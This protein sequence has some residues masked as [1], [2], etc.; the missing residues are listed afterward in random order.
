MEMKR[1][2][3][4]IVGCGPG[5]R[6]CVTAEALQAVRGA[7]VLIGAPRLLEL[8]P[9]ASGER[10]A[11][12][13]AIAEVAAAIAANRHRAVAV[14][15]TGDPG[16]AS[17]ARG[18]LRHFG[19]DACRVIAG[20][21]SVQVA[22]ARLGED[23]T[24]ARILSAHSGLPEVDFAALER[25]RAIA[26]LMGSRGAADWVASLA[27]HLGAGWRLYLAESLTLAGERVRQIAPPELRGVRGGVPSLSIL[28]RSDQ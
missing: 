18:V 21:S 6:E 22:F 14:L 3:I 10:I 9:E 4:D 17:L 20:V 25:E 16:L 2:A 15:V 28:L 26:V 7:E 1:A 8:F 27:A 19:R 12:S 13:G 23:W 11:S 5:A 24:G